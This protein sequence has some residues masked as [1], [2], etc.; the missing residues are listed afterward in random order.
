MEK[1]SRVLV[2]LA[3]LA[4]LFGA[5]SGLMAL[6]AQGNISSTNS[7]SLE[8]SRVGAQPMLPGPGDTVTYSIS[9]RNPGPALAG[10]RVTDTLPGKVN[11]LGNLWASSGSYGEAGGTITWTGTVSVSMPVTITFGVTVSGQITAPQ[12]ISNAVLIDDGVGT[13]Q[14][15]TASVVVKGYGDYLPL[16]TRV[17]QAS[18]SSFTFAIAADMRSLAGPGRYNTR[19]YFR[20]ACEAIA[21]LG[22]TAFM[23]SPGDVG[24]PAGVYWTI[25]N[26]L[27]ADY[28]W[29]PVVGNHEVET[30]ADMDWLRGYEYGDV[31]S[32]PPGCPVSTYSFDY[33]NAHF[34]ML[35]EYCDATGAAVD[36]TQSGGLF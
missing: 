34:V 25:T 21:A 12:F 6:S 10:A 29:F 7:Q 9:L 2:A 16:V 20:G 32:G 14:R 18:S 30:A 3:A 17:S 11:H 31:N 1:L 28:H 4:A 15:R 36:S 35:N 8:S 24:P 22:N 23:V 33:Q 27:G 5:W 19:Q 26:T 13:V